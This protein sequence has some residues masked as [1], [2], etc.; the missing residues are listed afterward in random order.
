MTRICNWCSPEHELGEKCSKCNAANLT[1]QGKVFI[2]RNDLC[3]YY[4]RTGLRHLFLAGEGGTTHTIC[5]AARVRENGSYR[6]AA[7]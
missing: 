3:P 6:E 4:T 7:R 1:Q 5:E 2:C